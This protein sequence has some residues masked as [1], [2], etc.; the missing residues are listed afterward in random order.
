[1]RRVFLGGRIV[2]NAVKRFEPSVF[3]P[4]ATIED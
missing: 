1:M 2:H 4:E 3:C